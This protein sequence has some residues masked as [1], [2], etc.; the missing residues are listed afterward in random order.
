MVSF[1]ILQVSSSSAEARVLTIPILA[2]SGVNASSPN[3]KL[4]WSEPY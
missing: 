3:K 2:S 4:K 1:Y